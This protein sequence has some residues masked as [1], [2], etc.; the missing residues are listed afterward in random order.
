MRAAA[1]PARYWL[2]LSAQHRRLDRG[3]RHLR[4]RSSPRCAR[5][6]RPVARRLGSIRSLGYAAHT[7]RAS[8]FKP[9]GE[10]ASMSMGKCVAGL[11]L[12]AGLALAPAGMYGAQA[13]EE[14]TVVIPNPSAINV[15]PLWVAIGEG[16]FEEEGLTVEVE[17]VDGSAPVL[18]TMAAGQAEIGPPGAAPRLG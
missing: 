7:R 4:S 15:F 5:G 8:N 2:R 13:A 12:A 3:F 9:Q 16:Y 10:E 6:H 14:I 17:A 11:G 18:Q 1:I